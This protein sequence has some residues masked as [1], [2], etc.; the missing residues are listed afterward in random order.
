M[1][2]TAEP[3]ETQRKDGRVVAIAGPV[4]D[5]EFPPD[6]LPEINAALEM[7]VELEGET[8]TITAEVAQQIG[9]PVDLLAPRADVA[10]LRPNAV[11]PRAVRDENERHDEHPAQQ[12]P[13]VD[14]GQ[15]AQ[16]A[17]ELN[18]RPPG[19]VEHAEDQSGFKLRGV[20]LRWH[21]CLFPTAPIPHHASGNRHRQH[22][23]RQGPDGDCQK[24]RRDSRNLQNHARKNNRRSDDNDDCG[25][26][27]GIRIGRRSARK[28]Y[29]RRRAGNQPAEQSAEQQPGLFAEKFVDDVS[30]QADADN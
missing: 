19:V 16:A 30:A 26:T 11:D 12:K 4:V 1:T 18:D 23:R 29:R 6:A 8:I 10:V 21:H 28:T 13:P 27:S 9:E 14:P 25:G 3:T 22:H 24:R 15:H 2:V 7:D 17:H 5:V 20:F